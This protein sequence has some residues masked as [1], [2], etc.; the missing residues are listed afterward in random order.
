MT[1]SG[2]SIIVDE[3]PRK[4]VAELETECLRPLKLNMTTRDAT[5][6]DLLRTAPVGTGP[7]W[8]WKA[9]HPKLLPPIAERDANEIIATVAGRCAMGD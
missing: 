7:N 2:R 4:T 9:L 3:M 5:G 1:T 6:I 8:T